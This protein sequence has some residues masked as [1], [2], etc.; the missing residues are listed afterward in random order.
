MGLRIR[1]RLTLASAGLVAVILVAAGVFVYVRFEAD[2]RE[3][4]DLGLR[5]RAD[6]STSPIPMRSS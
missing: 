6:A 2:L 4:V 5:S 1:T 3:T